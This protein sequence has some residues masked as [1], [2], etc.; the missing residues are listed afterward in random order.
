MWR[1]EHYNC[2]LGRCQ[3]APLSAGQAHAV[4]GPGP[5]HPPAYISMQL[6]AASPDENAIFPLHAT[7]HVTNK[8][9]ATQLYSPVTT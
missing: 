2:A 5:A 3:P 7:P 6:P 9:T 8:E 1:S 4:R